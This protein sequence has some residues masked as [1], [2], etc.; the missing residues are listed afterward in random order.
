MKL[1]SIASIMKHNQIIYS[2]KRNKKLIWGEIV[3]SE[4]LDVDDWEYLE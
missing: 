4:D 1:K 3:E 2:K